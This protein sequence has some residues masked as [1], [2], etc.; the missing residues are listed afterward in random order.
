MGMKAQLGDP[1]EKI[2]LTAEIDG[3]TNGNH[4][5]YST[6][7]DAIAGGTVKHGVNVWLR[8][9]VRLLKVENLTVSL[10]PFF[11]FSNEQIDNSWGG[12][13]LGF[14]L[15]SSFYH[16]GSSLNLSYQTKAFGKPLTLMGVGTGNFSEHGLE[17]ASGMLGAMFSV[18]RN[19]NTHLGLGAIYLLGTSVKW[20]LFPLI[21][22]S[23]RFNNNWSI[24][25]MEVNN[26]L[27]YHASQGVKLGV[28]MEL[29]TNKHYFHPN[30]KTLPEKAVLS[31]LSERFGVF[32]DWQLTKSVAF[33]FGAGV[34]VPIYG[35]LQ[36]SGYPDSYMDIS[37]PVK[38]FARMK[39]KV[40]IL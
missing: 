34:S 3:A 25:C 22:Y 7:G 19:R 33:N 28:G 37:T 38:P 29:E 17:N 18:I 2:G 16:F 4:T 14:T 5:W 30:S 12:E 1:R 20:P 35:R 9:N 15:P 23:H 11:N 21:V 24:N 39:M 10:S 13:N 32:A 40:S 8:A 36:E 26:F 31:Q 6:A 27:Y